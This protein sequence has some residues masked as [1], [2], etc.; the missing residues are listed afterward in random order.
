MNFGTKPTDEQAAEI[1]AMTEPF[2]SALAAGD[3]EALLTHYT[4]DC[5]VM[6]PNSPAL[7]GKDA[8]RAWAEALPPISA[9]S[10]QHDEIACFG[11][12]AI[13]RGSYE[14]TLAIPGIP[15]PIRDV[16][17]Y[18][19]IRERQAD[20]RWLLTRDIFNTDMPVPD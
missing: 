9:F 18:M 4:D 17:S 3:I 11:D 14:M 5:V 6:P 20:G 16:G 8:I 1:E 13:L 10:G 2:T 19:E 7:H 15:E 12:V